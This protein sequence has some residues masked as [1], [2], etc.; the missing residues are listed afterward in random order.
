MGTKGTLLITISHEFLI[1][2]TS[3]APFDFW[4]SIV[5]HVHTAITMTKK[6]QNL[7]QLDILSLLVAPLTCTDIC[8]VREIPQVT[9]DIPISVP[10]TQII[11]KS[12]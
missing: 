1:V 6:I 8:P 12:S 10:D 5:K 9:N 2:L 3:K 4:P 11:S 7:E